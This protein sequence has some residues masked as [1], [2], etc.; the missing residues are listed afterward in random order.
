VRY[1]QVIPAFENPD[2]L[3]HLGYVVHLVRAGSLP[4]LEPHAGGLVGHEAIQTPLYYLSAAPF[5][6]AARTFVPRPPK[7]DRSFRFAPAVAGTGPHR[8]YVE[9]AP[10]RPQTRALADLCRR[11]RWV[12]VAWG[13]LAALAGVA[14]L[15]TLTRGDTAHATL[16]LALLVLNPRFVETCASVGND[17]ACVALTTT[18]LLL[19]IRL[20][21]RPRAPT[22]VDGLVLG[23]VCGLAGLAK[24]NGLAATLAAL[25]A[26]SLARGPRG[27]RLRASLGLLAGLAVALPWLARSLWPYGDLL[28]QGPGS[29]ARFA[30]VRTVPLG[31]LAFFMEEFQGARW[32]YW[33][34][35]GQFAVL[36]DPW[37]YPLLDGV[38]A[39][40]AILAIVFVVRELRSAPDRQSTAVRALPM[41]LVALTGVLF[42]W[43]TG[44]I[45]G[46]QGRLLFPASAPIAWL[47]AGGLLLPFPPRARPWASA[48]GVVVMVAFASYVGWS[49]LP[50]AYP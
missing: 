36:A 16:A 7:V 19:A 3:R 27:A 34:V 4:G 9:A 37:V 14:L 33:A 10:G 1:L 39:C 28:G 22:F 20:L 23:A 46:S 42:L 30:P 15:V 40:G 38:L 25:L 31:P 32:S 5:G 6:G 2:E 8:Y 12:S 50:R 35:F 26:V 41:A 18:A 29:I 45:L 13:V 11:L 49:V 24:L 47:L 21:E 17:I 44:Q 43:Y 48:T